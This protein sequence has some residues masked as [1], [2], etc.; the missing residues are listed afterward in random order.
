MKK[1]E[2]N[3]E[4]ILMINEMCERFIDNPETNFANSSSDAQSTSNGQMSEKDP[5]YS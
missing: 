3:L 5:P 1:T 4:M 2:N